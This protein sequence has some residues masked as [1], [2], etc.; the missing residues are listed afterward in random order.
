M[1]TTESP[2]T[3]L[4]VT[5]IE[6]KAGHCFKCHRFRNCEHQTE[7]EKI[8]CKDCVQTL[9]NQNLLALIA[10][11]KPPEKVKIKARKPPKQRESILPKILEAFENSAKVMTI[12]DIREEFRISHRWALA[13]VNKLTKQG[14]ITHTDRSRNKFYIHVKHIENLAKYEGIKTCHRKNV[15]AVKT[16]IN[17]IADVVG[18][19]EIFDIS[20]GEM[21]RSCVLSCLRFLAVQGDVLTYTDDEKNT[22]YFASSVNELAIKKFSKAIENSLE[23]RI[24]RFLK[25]GTRSRQAMAKNFGKNRRSIGAISKVISRLESQGKIRTMK[26]GGIGIFCE[27]IKE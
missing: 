14:L 9:K 6:S 19:T 7:S 1:F 11:P 21:S 16:A 17:G 22:E 18:A 26:I 3:K 20:K 8:I 27:L 13:T 15:A 23:N 2:I 5:R 10:S 12:N 4:E 24:L 25:T